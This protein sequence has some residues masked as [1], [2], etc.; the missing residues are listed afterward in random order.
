MAHGVAVFQLLRDCTAYVEG[1]RMFDS[2]ALATLNLV[3][4]GT[5]DLTPGDSPLHRCRHSAATWPFLVPSDLLAQLLQ[6]LLPKRCGETQIT[7]CA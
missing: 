4:E 6:W 5:A 3:S 2:M 1:S 7:P